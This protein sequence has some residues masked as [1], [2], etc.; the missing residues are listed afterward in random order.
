MLLPSHCEIDVVGDD[1]NDDFYGDDDDG[2]EGG[3]DRCSAAA[4]AT[5]YNTG[6]ASKISKAGSTTV[7]K[8]SG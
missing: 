5:H 7:L 8:G 6:I 3:G 1:D 2:D 4:R